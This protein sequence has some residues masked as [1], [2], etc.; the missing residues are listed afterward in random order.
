MYQVGLAMSEF[1]L[2]NTQIRKIIK[3]SNMRYDLILAD[4]L[5][6]D[7]L[8]MFSLKYD[9]PLVTLGIDGHASYM[10]EAMG[11]STSF[12]I[13]PHSM[14]KYDYTMSFKQRCY[15]ALLYM[16]EAAIRKFS[17]LP[18]QNKLAKKYFKDAFDGQPP[19][20]SKIQISAIIINTHRDFNNKPKVSAQVDIPG[21]QIKPNKALHENLQQIYDESKQVI[22]FSFG[23]YKMSEMPKEKFNAILEAFGSLD[24]RVFMKYD[25]HFRP[26]NTPDNVYMAGGFAQNDVLG[27]S[28]VILF[29][30]NGG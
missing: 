2:N 4:H 5:L 22:Y 3:R 23:S 20:L 29:I 30:T 8:F 15:N 9:C 7:S 21:I 28:K 11:I 14:S 12:T 26:E 10:D 18:A 1:V 25:E 27:K 19:D 17:Y 24:K 16:Y 13:V 6:I